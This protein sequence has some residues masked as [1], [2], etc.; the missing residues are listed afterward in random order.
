MGNKCPINASSRGDFVLQG[1]DVDLFDFAVKSLA[2]DSRGFCGVR[3]M[4]PVA[5]EQLMEIF[6]LTFY[7]RFLGHLPQAPHFGIG[8]G[9]S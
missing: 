3:D 5:A 2:I 1:I 8:G 4:T 9:G 6:S 7:Q